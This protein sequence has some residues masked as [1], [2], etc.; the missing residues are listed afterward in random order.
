MSKLQPLVRTE[1]F[2]PSFFAVEDH[3]SDSVEGIGPDKLAATLKASELHVCLCYR[4]CS[5]EQMALTVEHKDCSSLINAVA[6]L[7][8]RGPHLVRKGKATAKYFSEVPM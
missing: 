7:Q 2:P 3:H 5:S 8:M 1:Y 4:L 6:F